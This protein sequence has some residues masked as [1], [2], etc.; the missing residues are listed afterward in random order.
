[1]RALEE[2]SV[3]L[4]PKMFALASTFE[5]HLQLAHE[6]L[7]RRFVVL[8][9]AFHLLAV[10]VGVA[11][12]FLRKCFDDVH[13]FQLKVKQRNEGEKDAD[14]GCL[15]SSREGFVKMNS[16]LLAV[17]AEDPACRAAFES[18]ILV[19]LVGENPLIGFANKHVLWTLDKVKGVVCSLPLNSWTQAARHA[20]SSGRPPISL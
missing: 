5:S 20:S 15:R 6:P 11:Q 9:E 16:W 4:L 1:M 10:E 19:E 17:A 2:L 18:A 3:S 14:G 13:A 8:L 7:A 12:R